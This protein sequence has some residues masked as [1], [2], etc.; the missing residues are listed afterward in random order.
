MRPQ[1]LEELV[2][3][4]DSS[5]Q[6]H[7]SSSP[8]LRTGQTDGAT[9]A[10]AANKRYLYLHSRNG[11]HVGV[12]LVGVASLSSAAASR[13]RR[14]AGSSESLNCAGRRNDQVKRDVF[15]LEATHND[16]PHPT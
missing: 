6:S 11:F 2:P 5:T 12:R 9:A 15:L 3:H 14:E 10:R 16:Q 7:G 4:H 1:K 8:C 13:I